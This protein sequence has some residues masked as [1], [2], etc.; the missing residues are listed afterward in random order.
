[1]ICDKLVK[2]AVNNCVNNINTGK[3]Q[4]LSRKNKR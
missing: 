3:T 1:M 2:T 4:I